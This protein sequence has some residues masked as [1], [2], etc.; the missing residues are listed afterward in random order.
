MD[1]YFL[2]PHVHCCRRGTAFVFLDLK[3]DDYSMVA[4][5]AAAALSALIDAKAPSHTHELR[6]LEQAGLLTRDSTAG[7]RLVTTETDVALEPLL[8]LDTTAVSARPWDYWNFLLACTT[9]KARLRWQ[10][11]ENTVGAVAKRK[12]RHSNHQTPDVERARQLT[13]VFQQLRSLFPAN[14]LCLFDSLALLEFLARYDIYPT[15]VFAVRLEPWG[16]HC[17][18]QEGPFAFNEDVEQTASYTPIMAV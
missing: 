3:Q 6:E 15:W 2:P 4:G 10:R 7:R 9:A 11:I 13:A 18:I 17:W 5:P 1:E 12:A 16:A 14:R 8:D